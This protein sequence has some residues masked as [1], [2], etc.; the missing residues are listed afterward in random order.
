MFHYSNLH[1][2]II[3]CYY[4]IVII[5]II[6]SYCHH[7]SSIATSY[8]VKSEMVHGGKRWQASFV[9]SDEF[10]ARNHQLLVFWLQSCNCIHL[11][12]NPWNR[13]HMGMPLMKSTTGF[14]CSKAQ[15]SLCSWVPDVKDRACPDLD[16]CP[17][18]E[19]MYLDYYEC[20]CTLNNISCG[21]ECFY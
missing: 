20:S 1:Q 13:S 15:L 6:S 17:L 4:F 8:T 14:S 7:V 9:M 11:C 19:W 21:L 2:I 12:T 5:I 3:I 16:F 18:F 10:F